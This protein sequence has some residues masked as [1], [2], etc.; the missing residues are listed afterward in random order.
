[1]AGASAAT[2]VVQ[3]LFERGCQ[4]VRS[5]THQRDGRPTPGG[6]WGV[7]VVLR[8]D[9]LCRGRLHAAAV[10]ADQAAGGRHWRTGS[11]ATAHVTIRA[12]DGHR[13]DLRAEEPAV[14]RWSAALARAAATCPTLRLR[15]VG[16]SLTP[17]GVIAHAEPDGQALDRL[18]AVLGDELGDDGWLEAGHPRDIWYASLVHFTGPIPEPD[19]LIDWASAHRQA[20]LGTCRIRAAHLINWRFV[21]R[22]RLSSV[23]VVPLGA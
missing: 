20:D 15:F 9:G 16:V 10:A 3:R 4:A 8:P 11:S 6:R 22:P 14:R 5:G 21:D 18:A 7:A 13:P 12:I 1:M 19:R 2:R 23:A 17:T